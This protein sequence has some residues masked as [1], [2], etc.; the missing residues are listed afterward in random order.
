MIHSLVTMV[1]YLRLEGIGRPS[2]DSIIVN[3]IQESIVHIPTG[4]AMVTIGNYMNNKNKIS[5]IQL[6]L[7]MLGNFAVT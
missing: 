5:A 2:V 4:T 6:L 3:D 1:S 7:E